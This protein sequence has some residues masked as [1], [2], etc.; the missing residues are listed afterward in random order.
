MTVSGIYGVHSGEVLAVNV[1][2]V[3]LIIIQP[4]YGI[5]YSSEYPGRR[6]IFLLSMGLEHMQFNISQVS[7]ATIASLFGL[8]NFGFSYL[9]MDLISSMVKLNRI[10]MK[11]CKAR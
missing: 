11:T 5:L 6:D 7:G 10:L 9:A 2:V 8:M 1:E 3:D 4:L